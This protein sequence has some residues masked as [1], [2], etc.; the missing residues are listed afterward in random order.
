MKRIAPLA[1]LT[2]AIL[3]S[4]GGSST[5]ETPTE[6]FVATSGS[7]LLHQNTLLTIDTVT[8]N[9]TET[10]AP[11]DSTVVGVAAGFNGKTSTPYVELI[12]GS[13][14]DT[15]HYYQ[16]GG[17]L[18]TALPLN[19]DIGGIPLD[20]GFKWAKIYDNAAA[21]WTA[22]ADTITPVDLPIGGYKLSAKLNFQG[23]SV[24]TE[25]LTINGT[26]VSAKKVKIDLNAR[27]Y[28]MAGPTSLPVDVNLVVFY[29][30]ADKVGVV[31]ME[32]PATIIN[33]G[34]LGQL[35][36]SPIQAVP[37]IRSVTTKYVVK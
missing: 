31:K 6:T 1:I 14:T 3:V 29:W 21:S 18:Y 25:N 19:Y 33:L 5:P 37:G 17:A 22:L 34:L 12:G 9:I 13:A 10:P 24:G 26:T 20:L 15:S 16:D 27:L 28:A 30:L 23:Q 32:Q 7:Y 4:C 35:M 8:K 11:S 36:G 2:A